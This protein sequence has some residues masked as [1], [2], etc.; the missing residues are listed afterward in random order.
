MRLALTLA[1]SC[2]AAPLAAQDI[3]LRPPVNCGP[4]TGTTCIIQHYVDTDPSPAAADHRCGTL[5]YDGHKG[6][7]F[8]VPTLAEMNA[9]ADVLAA[10]PGTVTAIRDGMPDIY[11]TDPNAPDVSGR[12]C[13][14][15]L[16]IAHGNG[17]ETQYCHLK[18]GSI[19]VSKDQPVTAGQKIGQIGLSGETSFPHVHMSLRRNGAVVDPFDPE[20]TAS[21]GPANTDLWDD[22]QTPTYR[23]G[24]ILSAGFHS[25]VPDYDALKQGRITTTTL[26]KTA[27]ALVLWGYLFGS[28]AGDRVTFDI[29]GPEGWRFQN[30]T[31]L[32]RQQAELFRASG[33]RRPAQGWPVGTYTGVFSLIRDGL[34]LQSVEASVEV[35]N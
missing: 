4:G 3:Q 29:K 2:A 15:G 32:D 7:D 17:W 10:A 25:A 31:T 30:D 24:G 6:T 33:K 34:T 18:L 27:D 21:C 13:G 20:Q 16:V 23:L 9:G 11:V 22:A 35:T 26:P 8:R 19:E 28:Q 14:N 5:T 1:L 12:E